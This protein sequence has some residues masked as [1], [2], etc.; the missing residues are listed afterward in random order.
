MDIGNALRT[1]WRDDITIRSVIANTIKELYDKPVNINSVKTYKNTILIKTHNPLIN[2]ELQLMSK[3][4]QETC[5]WKLKIMGITL[6]N[7][8][9]IKF[10]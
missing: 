5:I 3:Q 9:Q 7:T 8:T 6:E 4:I 1:S 2:S 10:I